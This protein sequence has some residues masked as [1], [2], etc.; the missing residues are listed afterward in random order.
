MPP[1]LQLPAPLLG[2]A[3]VLPVHVV[4]VLQARFVIWQLSCVGLGELVPQGFERALVGQH[5]VEHQ[6]QV[7][8]ATGALLDDLQPDEGTCFEVEGS[9]GLPCGN[10]RAIARPRLEHLDLECQVWMHDLQDAVAL[11]RERGAEDAMTTDYPVQSAL[12]LGSVERAMN[13]ERTREVVGRRVRLHLVC[14]PEAAL[15]FPQAG[16]LVGRSGSQIRREGTGRGLLQTDGLREELGSGVVVAGGHLESLA[17]PPKWRPVYRGRPS[18][19]I[20]T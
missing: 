7:G 15:E 13:T 10:S 16:L 19:A 8:G 11:P 2:I 1:V 14:Q 20:P 9:P 6:G 18:K 12:Q 5:V 3:L 4:V 17:S